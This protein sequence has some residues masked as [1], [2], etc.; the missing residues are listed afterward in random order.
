M[1]MIHTAGFC[2]SNVSST[3]SLHLCNSCGAVGLCLPNSCGVAGFHLPNGCST[4]GLHLPNGLSGLGLV[5]MDGHLKVWH[6]FPSMGVHVCLVIHKY[7]MALFISSWSKITSSGG[8]HVSPRSFGWW[9]IRSADH[10]KRLDDWLGVVR[11]S[12]PQWHLRRS[13]YRLGGVLCPGGGWNPQGWRCWLLWGSPP[14]LG[15]RHPA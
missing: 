7:P 10:L 2:L 15:W 13:S 12:C 9:G 3:V 8:S 14:M 4:M 11:C 6:L 1:S 5:L